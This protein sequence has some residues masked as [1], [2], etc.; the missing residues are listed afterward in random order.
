MSLRTE[1]SAH[2]LLQNG[3]RRPSLLTELECP[4]I[5]NAKFAHKGASQ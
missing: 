5:V 2:K 3:R 4:I 1:I